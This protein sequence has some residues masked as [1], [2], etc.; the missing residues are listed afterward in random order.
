VREAVYGSS[1]SNALVNFSSGTK[2]VFVTLGGAT[3]T[4]N[5]AAGSI[6]AY[7]GFGGF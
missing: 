3:M 5:R 1:N 2:D 4:F 6:A 7:N